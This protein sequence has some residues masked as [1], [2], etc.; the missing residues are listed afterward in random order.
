MTCVNT[1]AVPRVSF[2]L[3]LRLVRLI[4]RPASFRPAVSCETMALATFCLVTMVTSAVLAQQGPGHSPPCEEDERVPSCVPCLT[5]C[6][7]KLDDC[8]KDCKPTEDCYCKPG[9]LWSEEKETCVPTEDCPVREMD[10]ISPV[11]DDL[12]NGPEVGP[13]LER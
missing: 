9:M 5:S 12:L 4:H 11:F 10:D 1:S 7:E 8:T 2:L 6:S 3:F 13:E